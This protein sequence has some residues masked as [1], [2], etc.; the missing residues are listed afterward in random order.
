[1]VYEQDFRT[2]GEVRTQRGYGGNDGTKMDKVRMVY[3]RAKTVLTVPSGAKKKTQ[4]T[5][6]FSP[7]ATKS[8]ILFLLFSCNHSVELSSSVKRS[9]SATRQKD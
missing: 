3:Y 1:M 4:N 5:P 7:T 8:L 2:E 6:L 9:I